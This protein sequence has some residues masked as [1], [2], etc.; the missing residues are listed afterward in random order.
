MSPG[1]PNSPIWLLLP[2]PSKLKTRVDTKKILWDQG[3]FPLLIRD[4]EITDSGTYICEVED[5]KIEVELLVFKC[6]WGGPGMKIPPANLPLFQLPSPPQNQGLSW[7]RLRP[8]WP[9]CLLTPSSGPA[10][11]GEGL[12]GGR[13]TGRRG[14]GGGGEWSPAWGRVGVMERCSWFPASSLLLGDDVCVT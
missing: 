9:P 5:R 11:G 8:D 2:G 10:G 14:G 1:Y 4:L 6:E 3:S 12:E 7:S 13:E